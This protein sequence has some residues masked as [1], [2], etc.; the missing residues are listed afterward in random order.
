M[1]TQALCGARIFTGSEFLDH[2]AIV[3]TA[4]RVER[5]CPVDEVEPEI[6]RL[7]LHGGVL[8]PGF[9]DLQTNGG[10][11]VL[12]NNAPTIQ[13]LQ[14]MLTAHRKGGTT[15][16]LPTL[17]T[18]KVSVQEQAL[19]AVLRAV[20]DGFDSV[21]GV[22]FEGP[23]LDIE[24]RGVHREDYVRT[25]TDQDVDWLASIT[26]CRVLLTLAPEHVLPGQIKTLTD[27]GVIVCAGHSAGSY[28]QTMNAI[29]EGLSGFTHVFNAMSPLGSREPG[30]VGAALSDTSSWCGI[31][32]DCHHVHPATVSI[33]LR[34][35][36][37][38]KLY[39]VTDSMATVGSDT[40]SFELYGKTIRERDGRLVNH[41]DRL[42]GSAISMI[43]AVRATHEVVGVPLDESL[44]MASLY[45]AQFIGESEQRGRIE[46]GFRADIVHFDERFDVLNTWV[47]GEQRS[48][49]TESEFN[50][51]RHT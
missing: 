33:A 8:A 47:A 31:I 14:T 39:L 16:L 49:T 28:Q 37:R 10:G 43:D 51:S 4:G 15:A 23:F 20:D 17:V 6:Q 46:T 48:H 32:V 13:S 35:K 50:E 26:Q 7:T 38:G 41:E 2:H 29:A 3:Q 11:G 34:A 30:V 18:D 12:F 40:K 1:Q 25:M 45:P 22:H 24:R 36:P 27:A 42:A 5:V 9:I 44:R 19:A 21:L